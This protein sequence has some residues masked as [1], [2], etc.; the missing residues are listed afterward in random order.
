MSILRD[1]TTSDNAKFN[2]F[3]IAYASQFVEIAG[4]SMSRR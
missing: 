2:G 4:F 3:H 1:R